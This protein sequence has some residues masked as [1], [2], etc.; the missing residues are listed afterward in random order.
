MPRLP[1]RRPSPAMIV[2]CLALAVSLGGT[3]IAAVEA[4]VPKNSVGAAQLRNNAV[5]SAKLA[6]N[7]VTSAKVRNGSLRRVD[8]APGQL[9]AGPPGAQGPAGPAGPQGPKGD[10]GDKGD[11]GVIGDVTVHIASVDVP[12]S[13]TE[14]DGTYTNRSV[15]AN[16]DSGE[17][18]ISGGT[19]W[20]GEGDTS[21]L[22]TVLSTPIY[23]SGAKKITGW[24]ARG[25]ND[26]TSTHKFEVYVVCTK[27]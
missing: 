11:P 12:A 1:I 4:I 9:L 19:N 20:E 14:G 16:C 10:K 22:V 6:N 18:G 24:R 13:G 21:E 5:T 3:G 15:Q 17:K 7:A 25:G 27:A 2:A 26:T 23:D 8:F